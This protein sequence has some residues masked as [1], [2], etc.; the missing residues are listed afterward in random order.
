MVLNSISNL[1]GLTSLT[2][3]G[4]ADKMVCFPKDFLRNLTLLESLVIENYHELKVLPR[5]L[6][7]LVTLKSLKI[8]G[9]PKLES[10]PEEGL[11]GCES[12]QSLHIINCR[13]LERQCEKG[14]GEDWY[15]I[16]HI[17]EITIKIGL[18]QNG[19][20]CLK[21]AFYTVDGMNLWLPMT[22]CCH[23]LWV[24]MAA[25]SIEVAVASNAL[26]VGRFWV[27]HGYEII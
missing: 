2:I 14:K 13:E 24:T 20:K 4:Y 8:E 16:A 10:L 27:V 11:R 25:A 5:D 17:P 6:A 12:F 21:F 19:H 9:C 23:A 18:L 7:S 3:I 1:N 22:G 26:L 15:K